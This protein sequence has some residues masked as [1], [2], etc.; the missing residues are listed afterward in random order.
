MKLKITAF[1]VA[2]AVLALAAWTATTHVRNDKSGP[3]AQSGDKDVEAL[4][5]DSHLASLKDSPQARAYRERQDFEARSKRFLRDAATLGPV[6][7]E[8]QA[9]ALSM[10]IDKYEREA[11]LS[12]GEALLLRSALIKA[13]VADE[14]RQATQI[15][16][17]MQDYRE[18]A[19]RGT[20]E[21][22]A[23]HQRDP[24]FQDYKAHE[25]NIVAE[26]MAMRSIPGGLSRDEYLRQRLQQAREL[27]YGK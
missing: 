25:R 7:R 13:T 23:Q 15:A 14:A 2:M 4:A 5:V 1:I 11:G 18:R 10:S 19:D 26:I 3:N 16:D 27:A 22:L 8:K 21:Y 20:A 9:H 12:A 24:R 6:E 17:L